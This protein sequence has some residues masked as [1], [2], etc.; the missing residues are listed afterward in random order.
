MSLIPREYQGIGHVN[1]LYQQLVV[2][3]LIYSNDIPTVNCITAA[4]HPSSITVTAP[5]LLVL[6]HDYQH[7]MKISHWLTRLE[8]YGMSH[9]KRKGNQCVHLAGLTIGNYILQLLSFSFHGESYAVPPVLSGGKKEIAQKVE[10]QKHVERLRV[11]FHVIANRTVTT[12]T[13]LV[14]V[15]T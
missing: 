1:C 8:N 15:F 2:V 9:I 7:K 5:A 3:G 12:D 6:S 14:V 13:N 10:R 11:V 4:C